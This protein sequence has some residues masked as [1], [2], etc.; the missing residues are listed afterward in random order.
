MKKTSLTI[1]AVLL[2]CVITLAGC[3]KADSASLLDCYNLYQQTAQD[4]SQGN[5]YIF[6]AEQKVDLYS[7]TAYNTPAYNA[8]KA[9]QGNFKLLKDGNQYQV[10]TSV[11]LSFYDNYDTYLNMQNIISYENKVEQSQKTKLYNAINDFKASCQDIVTSKNT[12][13]ALCYDGFDYNNTNVNKS[14]ERFVS[15]YK[16]FLGSALQISTAYEDIFITG[17]IADS[18][19]SIAVGEGAR[20]VESAKLYLAK[21]VYLTYIKNQDVFYDCTS[22]Q[23]YND[24]LAIVNSDNIDFSVEP[25]ESEIYIYN[26][27]KDKLSNFK[28]SLNNYEVALQNKDSNQAY[29]DYV[30]GFE[31][32]V[33]DFATSVKANLTV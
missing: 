30:D 3:T 10:L 12:L 22:Q 13:V 24:L 7:E 33:I 1:I 19:N 15:S 11:A 16:N 21:Y 23:T 25:T 18:L 32:V 17:M 28:T 29:Q 2:L 26:F 9:E 8:I 20:L 27:M 14:L 4:Y 31:S 6:T 5:N